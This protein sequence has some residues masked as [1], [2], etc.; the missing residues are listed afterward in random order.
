MFTK[1]FKRIKSNKGNSLAEFAVTTA[2]MATLATTAAP[3]FGQ[4]GAGAKEKKTMNNI[5]KILTVANNFYNQT[6]S[7]E[8]KGRFPGQ[9]KYDVAVGGITL[10]EGAQ[11][12]ET[13]ESYIETI[14][15][16]KDSYTSELG[17]FVYV[18]STSSDDDDALQGDWMSLETS[19][20]FDGNDE[21]GA[22]DF[23]ND[24]GNNGMSSPFQDGSYAYLVIP[25]SGSGT[26]AQAPVVV[27]IDTENPSKL[28]K[29]L[30]P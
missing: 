24:F 15:D 20:V 29:T 21:I 23:K 1:F 13:L 22:L 2:M 18:F 3:K 17:E 19:V 11:T 16:A 25:G 27:V 9:E 14:L 4:V 12:D 8:G 26:S 7:E 5:D 10:S 6:L 28:H 30:V